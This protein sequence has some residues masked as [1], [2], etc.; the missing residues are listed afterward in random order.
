MNKKHNVVLVIASQTQTRRLLRIGFKSHGGFAMQ[1]AESASEGLE[2]AKSAAPDLIILDPALPDLHGSTVLKRIRT[3]SDVP[4]IVISVK[5]DESEKVLF[6]ELG[7]DDYVTKPFG[8]AELVARSKAALRRYYKGP[9]K[10]LVV[11]VG[12]LLVNLV[13]RTALLDNKPIQLSPQQFHLL[14]LLAIN[15]GS[16]VTHKRLIMEIWS[17]DDR[18]YVQFLRI[19]V[20][21]VRQLIE[22]DPDRPRLLTTDW[23]VGYRLQSPP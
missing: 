20:R 8:V 12:P 11:G 15:V 6:F 1:E 9:N 2:A 10:N 19:V 17:C 23:G 7:A 5:T 4:V 18:K 16:S 22:I 14:R 21:E 13:D 3:C